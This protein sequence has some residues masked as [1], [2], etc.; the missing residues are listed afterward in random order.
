MNNFPY[1]II[2]NI[3]KYNPKNIVKYLD[4]LKIPINSKDMKLSNSK[5][6]QLS[7][8][9][10]ERWK[11]L[12]YYFYRE[13]EISP[14]YTFINNNCS[15]EFANAILNRF[16]Y[17]NQKKECDEIKI[18]SNGNALLGIYSEKTGRLEYEPACDK[19]GNSIKNVK[20]FFYAIDHGF[21]I[22]LLK[23]G[24]A[25]I[26][27]HNSGGLLGP[28]YA[29]KDRITHFEMICDKK[30]NPVE[31]IASIF[32]GMSSIFLLLKTGEIMV[33]GSNRD[34]QLGLVYGDKIGE[35]QNGFELVKDMAGNNIKDVINIFYGYSNFTVLLLKTGNLMACGNN[36][37]GQLGLGD[38]K[39][40]TQFTLVPE[41]KDVVNVLCEY[42]YTVLLLRT[43]EILATGN[44]L[45]KELGYNDDSQRNK[46]EL[47]FN[48]KD[49]RKYLT[50]YERTS[51]NRILKN[52]GISKKSKK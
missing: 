29:G 7:C 37:C 45:F 23:S 46:F 34:R 3:A 17:E 32:L 36:Y 28:D 26:T 44:D 49:R 9:S 41:I 30:N 43:G 51:M 6:S 48:I 20:N 33:R 11:E 52:L 13:N 8:F 39:K 24:K 12:Y 2:F 35:N 25:L 47:I 10:F 27:G 42:N 4:Q 16:F 38:F 31:N 14:V 21:H 40:R 50:K 5:N 15:N 18:L 1:E 19:Q 22:I